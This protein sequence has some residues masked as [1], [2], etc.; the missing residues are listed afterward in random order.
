MPNSA[1]AVLAAVIAAVLAPAG[2]S[3]GAAPARAAGAPLQI[4]PVPS[5]YATSSEFALTVNGQNVPV[6]HTRG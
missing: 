6:T 5:I 1:R 3:V 4:Y 2:L